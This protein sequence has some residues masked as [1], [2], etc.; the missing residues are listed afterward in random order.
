MLLMSRRF[1]SRDMLTSVDWPLLLL[2]VGL[3]VVN[4]ALAETGVTADVMILLAERGWL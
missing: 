2:F 3:F 4:G 1:S